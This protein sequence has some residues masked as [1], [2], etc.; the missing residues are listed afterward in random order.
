MRTKKETYFDQ[1]LLQH[2]SR[3][4]S[5]TA[6]EEAARDAEEAAWAAGQLARDAEATRLV[7][8]TDDAR[9]AAL[10]AKLRTATA[11][12]I[13]Q[14]VDDEVVDLASARTMLKRILL[15]LSTLAR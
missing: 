11:A 15:V 7:G 14:Y 8:I 12:E 2:A 13:S 5:L 9:R 4:V 3:E 1:K 10:V 6:E